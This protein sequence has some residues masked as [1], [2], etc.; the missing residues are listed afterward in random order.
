MLAT[1]RLDVGRA[2]LTRRLGIGISVLVLVGLAASPATAAGKIESV[3]GTVMVQGGSAAEPADGTA[4]GVE[5]GTEVSPGQLLTVAADS[6]ARVSFEDGSEIHVVGPAE[7]RYVSGGS[8]GG[9]GGLQLLLLSGVINVARGGKN[10]LQIGTEYP[11]SLSVGSGATGYAEVM[12][13]ELLRFQSKRGD[14]VVLHHQG[15]TTP[16]VTGDLPKLFNLRRLDLT[17]NPAS[18]DGE[19]MG[20][21]QYLPQSDVYRLGRRTIRIYPQDR[22]RVERMSDGGLRIS[23]VGLAPNEFVRVEVGFEAVLYLGAGDYAV[24]DRFGNVDEYTGTTMIG[25]PLERESLE[26]EVIKDSADQ[27]PLRSRIR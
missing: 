21:G 20:T 26:W 17:R 10:G 22:A 24:L 5:A 2:S 12:S 3:D 4:A 25:T 8:S 9:G 18:P 13:S 15:K 11:V 1:A 14:G 19:P 7:I 23:G 6:K 27:S 16:L